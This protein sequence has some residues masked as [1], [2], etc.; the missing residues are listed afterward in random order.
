MS[1]FNNRMLYGIFPPVKVHPPELVKG[2]IS[3]LIPE[4]DSHREDITIKAVKEAKDLLKRAMKLDPD[5]KAQYKSKVALM[6]FRDSPDFHLP[7]NGDK[8]D[9]CLRMA[10][11]AINLIFY[12]N[13][14]GL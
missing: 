6:L 7:L 13:E 14:E 3:D 1:D 11:K 5:I 9:W 2:K 8:M 4:F 12:G 10:E